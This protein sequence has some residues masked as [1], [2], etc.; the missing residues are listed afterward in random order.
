[1]NTTTNGQAER[2][3]PR[4]TLAQRVARH[5]V[6]FD[7]DE[8]IGDP[9]DI[10][11]VL[12]DGSL[13][14]GFVRAREL[15]ETRGA[16][17]LIGHGVTLR[18]TWPNWADGKKGLVLS[19]LGAY[20][21]GNAVDETA[22]L[23]AQYRKW[24]RDVFEPA[25]P[26]GA[27]AEVYYAPVVLRLFHAVFEAQVF[28]GTIGAL[29]HAA[30]VH[31]IGEERRAFDS[32]QGR[33]G[34]RAPIDVARDLAL[35]PVLVAAWLAACAA[36]LVEC[37][38]MR[39]EARR[40]FEALARPS[41]A[42]TAG[43]SL[44]VGLVPDWYRINK[45]LIDAGAI[46][47]LQ[48]SGRLGVLLLG[49]LRPGMRDEANL[50][51]TRDRD[52]LWAGLNGF[53]AELS[54]CEVAQ[55]VQ[56]RSSLAYARAVGASLRS[57][58]GV[59]RRMLRHPE[60]LRGLFRGGGMRSVARRAAAAS[61]IDVARSVLAER[62][63]REFVDT[64]QLGGRVVV[65]AAANAAGYTSVEAVVRSAGAITV[66]HT[67]GSGGSAWYGGNESAAAVQ[68][69]WTRP[70][71]QMLAHTRRVIAAGMPRVLRLRE[72]TPVVPRRVLLL[73]NYV[74]RDRPYRALP[75]E[76]FQ[77]ELL[78]VALLL[79][80]RFGSDLSFRWRPHP[81]DER[82]PV[83][84]AHRESAFVALSLD[85][86]LADDLNECD[87]L[88]SGQSTALIEAVLGD[89]PFFVHVIPELE[90]ELDW[91]PPERRFFRAEEAVGMFSDWVEAL[92]R[93]DPRASE[94]SARARRALFGPE[95]TPRSLHEGLATLSRQDR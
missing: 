9:R 31:L 74:H 47:E 4:A 89:V 46:P 40:S 49:T 91:V 95:G 44:W 67:H 16:V 65:F 32:L 50:K 43:P 2:H 52:E 58:A 78:R 66:E 21:A 30:R 41:K 39:V 28:M 38:R 25:A 26:A 77:Y 23:R 15:L 85:R 94:P 8:S 83:E 1:M 7:I 92:R 20:R 87:V 12:L 54:R 88:V 68:C 82:D 10:V 75:H 79:R 93:G 36:T 22:D 80:N 6:R 64:H 35:P 61:T 48:V 37:V 56:P 17:R 84:R 3:S 63:A 90:A 42:P 5:T 59:M 13:E 19:E 45:H 62:G 27:A 34:R 60:P 29:H 73:S 53:R 81:A 57:S 71:E 72:R 24:V 51:V 18:S 86:P 14:E 33:V 76:P 69:V 55:A 70:E 11:V